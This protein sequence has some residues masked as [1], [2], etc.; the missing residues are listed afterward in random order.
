MAQ[1]TF[2]ENVH[3]NTEDWLATKAAIRAKG[4]DCPDSTPTA[5]VAGKIASINTYESELINLIERD[6]TTINIPQGTTQIG[7]SSFYKCESLESVTIPNSV[8]SIGKSSFSWCTSLESVTIPNSVINLGGY[9]FYE[10]SSLESVTIP[11]GVES[12]GEFA[13]YNCTNFSNITLPMGIISIGQHAFEYTAYYNNPENW[14][15]DVLY[16]DNYLIKAEKTISGD[17]TIKN[18]TTIIADYAFSDFPSNNLTNIIIPDSVTNIGMYAFNHCTSLESVTIPNG[19]KKI[20]WGTFGSCTS[21]TLAI[22]PTSV[23]HIDDNA[24]ADSALADIY[25]AG[26]QAEWERVVLGRNA[27][28]SGT[29][30]HYNYTG[31]GSEL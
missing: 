7:E 22:I 18:G 30:I 20:N 2:I 16:I 29:T 14:E 17:H 10:C 21:L 5:Q 15:N 8:T 27:I 11:N 19:V 31:D 1:H 6:A 28:P 3:R 13:F 25:Y 23:T 4:V 24:F 9:A 12:I 26:T